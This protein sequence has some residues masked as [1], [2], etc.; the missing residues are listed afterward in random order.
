MKIKWRR[1]FWLDFE[2]RGWRFHFQIVAGIATLTLDRKWSW[3]GLDHP[4]FISR[5]IVAW[6]PLDTPP[7]AVVNGWEP[8]RREYHQEQ[9][10]Y[11]G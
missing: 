10:E 8:F 4:P 6:F 2:R 3:I 9:E 1:R 11:I 5:F 7:G